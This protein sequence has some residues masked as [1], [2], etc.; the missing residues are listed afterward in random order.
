MRVP[1]KAQFP[2]FFE[3]R[4]RK[5][6]EM[7][8]I[9]GEMVAGRGLASTRRTALHHAWLGENLQVERPTENGWPC[10][11]V[12]QADNNYKQPLYE[13]WGSYIK[14]GGINGIA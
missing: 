5:R 1:L 10:I 3:N 12:V 14:T 7:A 6:I 13:D 2:L 4:E 8:A 11:L 9:S